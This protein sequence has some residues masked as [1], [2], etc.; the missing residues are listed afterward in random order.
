MSTS[1][2]NENEKSNFAP[3]ARNFAAK[4]P[5][6]APQARNLARRQAGPT[7][8]PKA[9]GRQGRGWSLTQRRKGAEKQRVLAVQNV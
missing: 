7:S 5:N 6:L 3:Q 4:R 1:D 8:P 2:I 9:A